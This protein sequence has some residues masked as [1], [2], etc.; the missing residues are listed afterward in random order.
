MEGCDS[1]IRYEGESISWSSCGEIDNRP[2]ECS[3]IYVPMDH[4]ADE[5][6][7]DLSTKNFSIPLIRLRGR[8]ATQN[9]LLN[10]GGPGGSGVEFMFRKGEHLSTIVGD[11]FHLLSFDPRGIN[12]SQ[13]SGRC[14]ADG[15]SRRKLS[16]RR[17]AMWDIVNDS[18]AAF[19]WSENFGLA[20]ADVMGEHGKYL[21]TPQTAADMNNI[22]DALGQEDM[23]YWGFSYG[24]L[25]GQTYATMFPERSARVI[26]DGVANQWDWYE[27]LLD[28][29]AFTDSE[30]VLDGFFSECIK[31]GEKCAL[32]SLAETKEE[33]WDVLFGFSDELR[34]Q[35]LN[36]YVNSTTY[37][38]FSHANLW[39]DGLFNIL[40]KS[41]KWGEVA[42]TLT[43]LF[44][45]NATDAFLA[46]AWDT[47]DED[48]SSFEA[49][50]FIQ[51]NDGLAGPKYWPQ[52]REVMVDIILP[53]FNS[54]MFSVILYDD[55]FSKL[56]W[57]IPRV[58]NYVPKKDVQ[59]KHPLLILSTTYDPICPL[60]SARGASDAFVGS[61]IVEVE[62][63][64]HCSISVPSMC[65]AR[66]VRSFLYEGKLPDSYT[67][68]EVDGDYFNTPEDGKLK[69]KMHFEDPEERE[70]HLAQVKLAWD[71]DW[72]IW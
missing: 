17:P 71:M 31:A 22:L 20:C 69:A 38:L 21:N 53:F 41:E 62:G 35:P 3:T 50:R 14:Y 32:S 30:N 2:L 59:T 16:P 72:P 11:G 54:S 24:T 10:P 29:E 18:P 58:H 51:T 45:G 52:E 61:Q 43:K 49:G 7:Q 37:G 47:R 48:N 60:V 34:Q 1:D 64:G 40:Y 36:V 13:P 70:I 15:A 12:G 8:N 68:C 23:V 39:Q 9:L 56:H 55:L 26:I 63:Y 19:A 28:S 66:H 42:E 44:R 65:I 25:L 33:L 27:N 6:D 4:F 5:A 67:K 57:K 46:W